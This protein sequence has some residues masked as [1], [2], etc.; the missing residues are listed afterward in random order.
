[1]SKYSEQ[2]IDIKNEN[3]YAF[4]DGQNLHLSLIKKQHCLNYK[5]FKK[6][7][8]DKYKVKKVFYF[9]GFREKYQYIYGALERSG[10][11]LIFKKTTERGKDTKG[12]CDSDLIVQIIR[13]WKNFDKA[14]LV[15][16]D[17]DFLP[18]IEY[19]AEHDKFLRLGVPTYESRS[20]L[21]KK[22]Q[23][24]TFFV[25]R[26]VHKFSG[27]KKERCCGKTEQ[28]ARGLS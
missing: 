19:L 5:R 18:I 7:L 3:N 16:G 26:V 1:M 24:N 6:Y 13:E 12:N 25:E 22:F 23:K 10:F 2:A 28:A 21:L 15:S 11:I 14:L 20:F 4:I 8:C 9:L 17:G 27:E